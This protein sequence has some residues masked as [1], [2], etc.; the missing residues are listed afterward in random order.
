MRAMPLPSS[1]NICQ[2]RLEALISAVMAELVRSLFIA[3]KEAEAHGA[4][5]AFCLDL[6]RGRSRIVNN[7]CQLWMVATQAK[8]KSQRLRA[9]SGVFTFL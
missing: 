4:V 3:E 6:R 1:A 8:A 9:N 2:Q 5:A 7:R